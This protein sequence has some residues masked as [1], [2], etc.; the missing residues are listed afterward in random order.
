MENASLKA[1][2]LTLLR[3]VRQAELEWISALRETE[4]EA[5]GTFERWSAKDLLVH[6]TFWK[7]RR[8]E[9]L[10][11][12]KRGETPL[13]R[14]SSIDELNAQT[15]AASQNQR[16]ADAQDRAERAFTTLVAQTEELTDEELSDPERFT[17]LHGDALWLPILAAGIKH[18]YRHLAEF[19]LQQGDGERGAH[20]HEQMVEA[21]RQMQLPSD[22]FGRAIYQMAGFYVTLGRHARAL[23]ILTEAIRFQ[24]QVTEWVKQDNTW[25]ALRTLPAFQTI[26]ANS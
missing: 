9:M 13:P 10:A 15:F 14:V 18:P 6:I 21:M 2:L 1:K 8:V 24:P 26:Y 25:D 22:E 11:M 3:L 23:E 20:L 16:F 4:R 5:N 7:E 19:Y 17:W 12:V